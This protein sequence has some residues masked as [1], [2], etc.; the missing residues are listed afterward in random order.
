MAEAFDVTLAELDAGARG[1]ATDSTRLATAAARGG[2]AIS[3]AGSGV[4]GGPLVAALDALGDE[5]STRCSETTAAI[6]T[7]GTTLTADAERYS[8][9][10]TSAAAALGAHV[11][12]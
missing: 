12:R 10:D 11:A 2:G 3:Q 1:L 4:P 6:A 7:A 5:V 9:D 8:S